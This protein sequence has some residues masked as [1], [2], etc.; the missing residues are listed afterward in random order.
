M[1]R[2]P[3]LITAR[4]LFW[5]APLLLF[6]VVVSAVYATPSPALAGYSLTTLPM[7]GLGMWLVIAAGSCDD[8]AHRELIAA[9]VGSVRKVHV[10]RALVG[11]CLCAP[12]I[13]WATVMPIVAGTLRYQLST[14]PPIPGS[15]T[16]LVTGL[17]VH[18]AF[19]CVGVSFGTFLHRPLVHRPS[20]AVLAGVAVTAL[21]PLTP[22]ISVLRDLNHE[23]C[24]TVPALVVLAAALCAAAMTAASSLAA[25][26]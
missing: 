12:L 14:N 20:V 4:R 8:D 7:P 19:A 3:L 11:L 6:L 21:V 22:L 15:L 25:R 18:L 13:G 2:V 23:D 5:V 10:G 26:R 9:R 16:I 24:S 17:G 1:I